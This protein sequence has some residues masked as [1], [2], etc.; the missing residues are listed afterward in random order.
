MTGSAFLQRELAVA[1]RR[2]TIALRLVRRVTRLRAER[3]ADGGL[4]SAMECHRLIADRSA[5]YLAVLSRY[6]TALEKAV[7]SRTCP[8]VGRE[9]PKRRYTA[10]VERT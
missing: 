7:A 1:N 4:P 2:L 9:Y 6:N 10:G 3:P 5:A 8:R